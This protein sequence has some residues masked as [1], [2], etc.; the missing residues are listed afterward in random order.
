[1]IAG[2]GL[3]IIRWPTGAD[4]RIAAD[5]PPETI[6]NLGLFYGPMIASLGF[7]SVLFY[8]GYKL[9]PALHAQILS[10]LETRRVATG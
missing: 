6:I 10:E 9:T 8:T 7:I 1:M 4:I 5:V 3:E 2:W